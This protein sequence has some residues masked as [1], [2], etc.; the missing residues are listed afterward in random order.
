VYSQLIEFQV[1][2][3]Q[4]DGPASKVILYAEYETNITPAL[5]RLAKLATIKWDGTTLTSLMDARK[6]LTAGVEPQNR[7]WAAASFDGTGGTQKV[8]VLSEDF[9]KP[10]FHKITTGSSAAT[11]ATFSISVND[12]TQ[13]VSG[14]SITVNSKTLFAITAGVPNRA[15]GQFLAKTS[16]NATRDELISTINY[17]AFASGLTATVDTS[18]NGKLICTQNT[19]GARGNVDVTTSIANPG[20][21]GVSPQVLGG[22]DEFRESFIPKHQENVN[23]AIPSISVYE[24]ESIR[25]RYLSVAIPIGGRNRITVVLHGMKLPNTGA[26]LRMR[27]ASNSSSEW[28]VWTYIPLVG[29]IGSITST[30]PISKV[31]LEVFGLAQGYSLFEGDI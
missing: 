21:I 14:D 19:S 6:I 24:V 29:S 11:S 23:S 3:R 27:I 28:G 26:Q 18:A 22:I 2:N 10:R 20:S 17:G 15:L 5:S 31:Q 16:A 12:Y 8:H 9:K 30:T 7:F 1:L 13:I 25:D 4:D